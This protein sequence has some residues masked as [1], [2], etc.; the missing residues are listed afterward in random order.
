MEQQFNGKCDIYQARRR[1]RRRRKGCSGMLK[2]KSNEE[3]APGLW[4]NA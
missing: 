1:R 2:R 4:G 3:A